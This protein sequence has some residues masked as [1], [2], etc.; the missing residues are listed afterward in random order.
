MS[1]QRYKEITTEPSTLET[2]D[3]AM[4]KYI[5][6]RINVFCDTNEGFKKVPVSFATPERSFMSKLDDGVRD[7]GGSLIYPL[8]VVNRIGINK[9]NTERSGVPEPQEEIADIK[10]GSIIIGSKIKQNKTAVNQNAYSLRLNKQ[11]NLPVK[12][13]PIVKEIIYM[14]AP[15][16]IEVKYEVKMKAQ[17]IQQMNQMEQAFIVNPGQFNY[18]KIRESGHEYECF[19]DE[20][21]AREQNLS[22]LDEEERTLETVLNYRVL[23]YLVGSGQ[24]ERPTIVK[25]ETITE[26]K[27]PR[28]RVML[29]D[30]LL[31]TSNGKKSYRA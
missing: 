18:T 1:E 3:M 12:S 4:F 17:Y 23:G 30:R 9:S 13:A 5:D 14:S 22:N 11:L 2:I 8:V 31:Y 24:Q 7:D 26:V 6:E 27:F 28:E 16:F 15:V 21:F 20:A 10:G 25:R 29:G 19:M